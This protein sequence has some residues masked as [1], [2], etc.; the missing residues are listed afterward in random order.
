MLGKSGMLGIFGSLN[1]AVGPVCTVFRDFTDTS[2]P[3][4]LRSLDTTVI[5]TANAGQSMAV[6]QGKR[7]AKGEPAARVDCHVTTLIGG[8]TKGEDASYIQF[9][10]RGLHYLGEMR[11]TLKRTNKPFFLEWIGKCSYLFSCVF[12]GVLLLFL[13]FSAIFSSLRFFLPF[14]VLL[15]GVPRV[16]AR[17]H[18]ALIECAPAARQLGSETRPLPTHNAM[19]VR[20]VSSLSALRF[21]HTRS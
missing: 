6:D 9:L 11:A 5:A 18:P 12:W 13:L 1:C 20:S 7:K 19:I 10:H 2:W 17:L 21:R 3:R 16:V 14:R 8:G 4:K 15:L